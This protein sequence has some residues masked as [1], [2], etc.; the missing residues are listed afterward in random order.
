M[1]RIPVR[2]VQ[3]YAGRAVD[4]YLGRR[5]LRSLGHTALFDRRPPE[6]KPPIWGDLWYLYSLTRSRKPAV[7]L[8][9]GSGCSTIILAQAMHDNARED[10]P[11]RFVSVE[12][13]ER[14][15]DVTRTSMPDHLAPAVELVATPAVPDDLGGVPVWRYRN[16]P[17]V[18]PDLI[19]LDGPSLSPE[20]RAAVDVL[21]IEERLRPG[22]CL[23]VDGRARNVELLARAFLRRWIWRTDRYCLRTLFELVD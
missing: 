9:F 17:D 20:R 11:A 6:A 22:T 21:D 8:E 2:R 18:T 1:I 3:V 5:R 10:Q 13:D 12:G 14:W 19:Y 4:N 23:V 16:V 7:V 15:A